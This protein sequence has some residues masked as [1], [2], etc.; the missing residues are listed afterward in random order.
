MAKKKAVSAKKKSARPEI[1]LEVNL[2][3]LPATKKQIAIL[4]K[5]LQ[6]QV[7]TWVASDAPGETPPVIVCEEFHRP[8]NGK[9]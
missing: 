1:K 7:L 6:N 8:H 2:G 9:I 3:Q 4:K 5:A